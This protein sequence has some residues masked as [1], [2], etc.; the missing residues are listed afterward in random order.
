MLKSQL[1]DLYLSVRNN[2]EILASFNTSSMADGRIVRRADIIKYEGFTYFVKQYFINKME[3]AFHEYLITQAIKH[4]LVVECYGIHCGQE[5]VSL[6]LEYLPPPWGDM[7][8]ININILS[9]EDKDNIVAQFDEIEQF[10]KEREVIVMESNMPKCRTFWNDDYVL[11]EPKYGKFIIAQG[12]LHRC[13]APKIRF[14]IAPSNIMYNPDTRKIKLIDFD[15]HELPW[16]G[17]MVK[18]KNTLGL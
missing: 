1:D 4:E 18:I 2:G 3:H 7:Q 16:P 13:D 11:P 15:K 8:G 17:A 6:Y 10:M 5:W 9:R 12:G 14:E